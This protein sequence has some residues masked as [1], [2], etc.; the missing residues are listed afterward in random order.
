METAARQGNRLRKQGGQKRSSNAEYAAFAS[1]QEPGIGREAGQERGSV[2]WCHRALSRRSRRQRRADGRGMHVRRGEEE[3]SEADEES[4]FARDG[5][6]YLWAAGRAGGDGPFPPRRIVRDGQIIAAQRPPLSFPPPASEAR[7]HRE[8]AQWIAFGQNGGTRSRCTR[9]SS[10]GIGAV[11]AKGGAGTGGVEN[12]K[13]A[14]MDCP[15]QLPCKSVRGASAGSVAGLRTS[16]PRRKPPA[17]TGTS[18]K[19]R[20]SWTSPSMRSCCRSGRSRFP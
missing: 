18:E 15:S 8:T 5:R 2:E 1:E 9:D 6:H 12:E 13:A 3:S 19:Q 7:G 4:T 16:T 10:A 11:H 17:P 20:F 14:A